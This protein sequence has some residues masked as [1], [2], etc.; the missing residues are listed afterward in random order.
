[1]YSNVRSLTERCSDQAVFPS[2][3][4]Q[5]DTAVQFALR[6]S[7]RASSKGQ[8]E[9]A[10]ITGTHREAHGHDVDKKDLGSTKYE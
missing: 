10:R 4:T 5:R 9:E 7:L 8:E 6:A 1:M 3:A 2:P